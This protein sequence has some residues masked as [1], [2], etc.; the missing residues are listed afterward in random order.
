VRCND[1]ISEGNNDLKKIKMNKKIVIR[2]I[3]MVGLVCVIL[4]LMLHR[5]SYD[6][7]IEKTRI[8][9]NQ[10]SEEVH[11]V[12][13]YSGDKMMVINLGNTYWMFYEFKEDKVS[14]LCYYYE[15]PT[16]KE[17]KKMANEYLSKKT[18][19]SLNGERVEEVIQKGRYVI[20]KP[21]ATSY[22]STLR[23]EVVEM[24]EVLKDFYAALSE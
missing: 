23:T 11:E 12:S 20:L 22:Q 16:K 13:L 4:F 10:P 19:N 14:S 7:Y 1:F 5:N 2:N 3:V 9:T 15:Y 18:L 24:Y 17:A 6:R 8:K 21:V